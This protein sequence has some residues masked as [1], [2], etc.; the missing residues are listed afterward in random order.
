MAR[1]YPSKLFH[2]QFISIF[3][4]P[5]LTLGRGEFLKTRRRH[6]LTRSSSF[7]CRCHT[8]GSVATN[9]YYL[10]FLQG[11]FG[12]VGPVKLELNGSTGEATHTTSEGIVRARADDFISIHD[13]PGQV[14][15]LGTP[16]LE[17]EHVAV[18]PKPENSPS[19]D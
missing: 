19:E 11:S 3:P 12:V 18:S 15:F 10:S 1:M 13:S 17:Q 7:T 2:A 4:T 6:A 9:H 16:E 14:Q 5:L 8:V